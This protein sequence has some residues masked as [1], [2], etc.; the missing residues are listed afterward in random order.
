VGRVVEGRRAT[1]PLSP[2]PLVFRFPGMLRF[3][4]TLNDA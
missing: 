3:Y 4:D 1:A 2:Y